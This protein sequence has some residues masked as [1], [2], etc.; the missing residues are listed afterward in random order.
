M[1][2]TI[3]I[4]VLFLVSIAVVLAHESHDNEIEECKELVESG[5][6]CDMMNSGG[7]MN[8]MGSTMMDSG[9][10]GTSYG[11]GYWNVIT[12]LY[13]LLLLGIIVLIYLW[14]FR[15]W[16]GMKKKTSR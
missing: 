5:I 9:M 13:I 7:M 3:L 2:K 10:M 16:K 4:L 14:I 15:L 6:S 1:K 12:V 8:I 11:Y